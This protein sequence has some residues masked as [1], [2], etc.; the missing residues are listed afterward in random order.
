M[1][2]IRTGLVY[3]RTAKGPN[4]LCLG[5]AVVAGQTM[6]ISVKN[7]NIRKNGK[8]KAQ[9]NAEGPVTLHAHLPSKIARIHQVREVDVKSVF[10]VG[11]ALP[12]FQATTKRM[13]ANGIE[14]EAELPRISQ[15][16]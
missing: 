2:T 14:T 6:I 10:T 16:R 12:E 7:G 11:G 5:K 13:V 9:G 4:Y 8:C 3:Q 1:S 15:L